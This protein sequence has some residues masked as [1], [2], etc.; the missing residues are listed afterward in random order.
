MLD[1]IKK[2]IRYEN[3]VSDEDI[4]FEKLS[5]PEIFENAFLENESSKIIEKA[6]SNLPSDYRKIIE[7]YFYEGLKLREIA[8]IMNLSVGSIH[9]KKDKALRKLRRGLKDFMS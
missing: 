9:A 7:L 2:D 4:D 3:A 8:E 1:K 6:V 5:D